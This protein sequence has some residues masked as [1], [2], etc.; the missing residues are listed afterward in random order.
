[1]HIKCSVYS[2]P[3]PSLLFNPCYLRLLP[4]DPP[5]LFYI[6]A[7]CFV[8]LY[9]PLIL[10]RK[11]CVTETILWS[12][13]QWKPL[14]IHNWLLTDLEFGRRRRSADSWSCWGILPAMAV[15]GSENCI[16]N[17]FSLSVS[18]YILSA[19]FP[20]V[21]PTPPPAVP[22]SQRYGCLVEGWALRHHLF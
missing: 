19:L 5:S 2:Y 11:L 10:N 1:M 9:D 15:L 14:S 8:L 20:S 21:L 22:Q 13:T 4:R 16:S 18:S 6:W 3:L 7:F 17:L 12:F